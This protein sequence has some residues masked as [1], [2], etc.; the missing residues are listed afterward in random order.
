[1]STTKVYSAIPY[2]FNGR[3]VTVEG[4]SS[5]GL[6]NF[7]IIGMPSQ[8]IAESRDRIRSAIRNSLFS[9]P[10]DKITI[11]LAPAALRKRGT[12]LDLPIAI[13]ILILS[14][15]L[16]PQ[17]VRKRMVVGEVS[18]NGNLRPIRGILSIIETAI[19]H[20]FS[21]VYIPADNSSQATLL[22]DKI[23]IYP[24]KNLR[25]LW[26]A[27]KQKAHIFTLKLIVK[28]TEKDKHEH[29]L[30]QIIGQAQA[31]RALTIAIAGQMR[32]VATAAYDYTRTNW[33]H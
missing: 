6:P 33:H 29:Y 15:Q 26:L 9:F 27:L 17:D 14:S 5:H 16:L 30:D 11:N 23:K 2:G 10:R 13:A 3:L 21:E 12:G 28:N 19:K 4:D 24:I 31:K 1:M 18:L 20:H 8:T 22:A 25:E 7:N 32:T